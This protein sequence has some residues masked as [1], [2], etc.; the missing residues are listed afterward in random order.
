MIFTMISWRSNVLAVILFSNPEKKMCYFKLKLHYNQLIKLINLLV[1]CSNPYQWKPFIVCS[2]LQ[3][4]CKK[5][6]PISL[7]LLTILCLVAC[8]YFILFLFCTCSCC[9][10]VNVQTGGPQAW[11]RFISFHILMLSGQA[12][13]CSC[14]FCSSHSYISYSSSFL[15]CAL[16]SVDCTQLQHTQ[17]G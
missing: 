15:S 17:D 13:P 12:A 3:K 4:N 7:V 10:E 2:L 14:C 6:I 16:E 11:K 9:K 5:K 8:A 1:L